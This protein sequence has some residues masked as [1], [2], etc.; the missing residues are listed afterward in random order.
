MAIFGQQVAAGLSDPNRSSRLFDAFYEV[1]AT[2]GRVAEAIREEEKEQKEKDYLIGLSNVVNNAA[3]Y[4]AVNTETGEAL[5]TFDSDAYAGLIN[6]TQEM[7]ANA[8][9]DALANQTLEVI[10]GLN[11]GLSSVSTTGIAKDVSHIIRLENQ[12]E[13]FALPDAV[14]QNYKNQGLTESEIAEK[15]NQ[16]RIDLE[17]ER[18]A[19][20]GKNTEYAGFVEEEKLNRLYANMEQSNKRTAT[21]VTF[22]SN[23]LAAATSEKERTELMDTFKGQFDDG[24]IKQAEDK[25]LPLLKAREEQQDIDYRNRPVS[26]ENMETLVEKGVVPKGLDSNSKQAI[27][28]RNLMDKIMLDADI[29]KA[30][31]GTR[32]LEGIELEATMM[33]SLERFARE[34]DVSWNIIR[35]DVY[36]VVEDIVDD[37]DLK[38][39][40]IGRLQNVQ[41]RDLPFVVSEFIKEQN[42]KAWKRSMNMVKERAAENESINALYQSQLSDYGVTIK[43]GKYY[44]EGKE[45]TS[46]E[47]EAFN[48]Y[49]MKEAERLYDENF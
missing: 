44:A 39:Q 45:I 31:D 12:L 30:T 14:K 18:D 43:N 2:P 8:P 26:S 20:L 49:L 22:V 36:N 40:L 4:S 11:A 48:N 24:V 28:A 35:D 41:K 5:S 9:T 42:P 7:L 34:M 13:N 37:N 6:T 27:N 3:K 19:L 32:I 21:E 29:A 16:K 47:F 25:L 15:E 17:R 46:D 33:E 38:Q 23:A 10:N 1:G